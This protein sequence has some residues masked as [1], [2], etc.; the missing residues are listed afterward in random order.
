MIFIS[1]VRVVAHIPYLPNANFEMCE[2]CNIFEELCNGQGLKSLL[3]CI[4]NALI[5]P[6]E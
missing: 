4:C 1:N 3:I 6:Y 2:S 5:K